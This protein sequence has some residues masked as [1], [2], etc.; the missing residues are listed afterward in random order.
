M[1]KKYE[2]FQKALEKYREQKEY[3]QLRCVVPVD[4]AHLNSSKEAILNFASNDFLALS[5]H[6]HVKKNTIKYALEW[7][8]GNTGSRLVTKHLECH[9]S[10]E[11]KLADLVGKESSLLFSSAYQAQ[12]TLLGAVGGNRSLFFIDRFCQNSLIQAATSSQAKLL[13]YEHQNISQL[14]NLLEKHKETPCKAKVIISESLFGLSGETCD[15]KA[16]INLAEEYQV[17]LYID[18]THAMGMMGK[19][20]MGLASHR[21][22]IDLVT[23][24]FGKVCGFFGAYISLSHL[25]REYLLAFSPQIAET[26]VLPPAV[27][28][29]ISAALDLIPDMQVERKNILHESECLRSSLSSMGWDTREG[30]SHIIPLFFSSEREMLKITRELS[31]KNILVTHLSYPTVPKGISCLRL[32]INALHTREDLDTLKEALKDLKKL[33]TLVTI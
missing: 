7:G 6:P 26:T 29:A 13:R 33:P 3:S 11:E 30:N 25:M 22:G 15:L 31:R 21:S 2:H 10:V 32:T 9:W 24:A 28:G 14:R 16:L 17:L 23:G 1:N 18:D 5:K 8:A 12:Q 27:L 4:E 20:G 19:N